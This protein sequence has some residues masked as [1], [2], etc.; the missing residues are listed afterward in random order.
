MV[1]CKI[2][3]WV[4][5][6]TV[7]VPGRAWNAPMTG[8]SDLPFRQAAARLGANYVATEM[9]ACAQLAEAR[10]D[11][12]RRAALGEDGGLMVVQLVGH[13]AHWIARGARMAKAAGAHIIDLNF[14]CPAKEVTGAQS[15]AALMRDRSLA[16]NLVAAAVDAVDTPIT[17][18]MRLGWDD[19]DR[20]A[21]EIAHDAQAAGAQAV[22]VHGRTRRQFYSGQADWR[23]V[24]EVKRELSIPVVVNGDIVDGQ[25]AEM[26]LTE[27]GADAVMIGRASTGKPWLSTEIQAH[28]DGVAWAGPTGGAFWAIVDEHFTAAIDFYGDALGVRT[29]RKH[30]ARYVD[31]ALA[32]WSADE[33]AAVR[34]RLCRLETPS[35][36]GLAIGRLWGAPA[37][38]LAA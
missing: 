15:G 17:V 10:P 33:R 3:N 1:D 37:D 36:I 11:V 32:H 8:V 5:V 2:S 12:V 21:P 6:G 26:A 28:L 7:D 38:R 35:E 27:S 30:L 4:K 22:T 29:F 34:G 9:V 20:N 19:A 14:G 23:A 13:D 25:S 24:R 18:K 16:R 31:F